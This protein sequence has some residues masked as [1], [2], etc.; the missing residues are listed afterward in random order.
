MYK[1]ILPV[2]EGNM[3]DYNTMKKN[4]LIQHKNNFYHT[5]CFRGESF[6]SGSAKFGLSLRKFQA[7][8]PA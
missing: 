8:T 1:N 2:D 3:V 7:S 4:T 5:E 6:L